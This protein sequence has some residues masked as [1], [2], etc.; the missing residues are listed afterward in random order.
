MVNCAS[1]IFFRLQLIHVVD[2]LLFLVLE[3]RRKILEIGTMTGS[4]RVMLKGGRM[5]EREREGLFR[6]FR[7]AHWSLQKYISKF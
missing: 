1:K 7:D 4:E 2:P 6:P 3:M 5:R